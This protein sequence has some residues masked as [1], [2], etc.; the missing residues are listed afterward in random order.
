ML[1]KGIEY[2]VYTGPR[3]GQ[4]ILINN[5]KHYVKSLK[6]ATQSKK[7]DISENPPVSTSGNKEE[8]RNSTDGKVP[9]KI[10]MSCYV[11]DPEH[12]GDID[13][14]LNQLRKIGPIEDVFI[15]REYTDDGEELTYACINFTCNPQDLEN[16]KKYCE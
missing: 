11:P 4:Y 12:E 8:G 7:E 3:G 6:K 9:M 15:E 2:E 5:K 16:F 1:Y 10:A 13:W 14:Q